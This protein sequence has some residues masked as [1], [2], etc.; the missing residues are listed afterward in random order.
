MKERNSAELRKLIG[1]PMEV[2]ASLERR[3]IDA[4]WL[5][6][7]HD[8]VLE[9]YPDLFVGVYNQAIVA[10]APDMETLIVEAKSKNV[11]TSELYYEKMFTKLPVW[12]LPGAHY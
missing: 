7:M 11:K 3:T 8:L 1:D 12:V 10:A 2:S 6:V 9:E 5:G 4:E